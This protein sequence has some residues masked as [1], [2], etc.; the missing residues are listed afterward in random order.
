MNEPREQLSSG[1]FLATSL[2]LY[3]VICLSNPLTQK[4][5]IVFDLI[6]EVC[7]IYLE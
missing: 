7:A 3:R 1:F 4:L 5:T 2:A 6:L